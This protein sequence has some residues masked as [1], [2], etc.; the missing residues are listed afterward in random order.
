MEDEEDDVDMFFD[1]Y[2]EVENIP[3]KSQP[4]PPKHDVFHRELKIFEVKLKLV[5]E[6]DFKVSVQE[7]QELEKIFFALN[8]AELNL[9][10]SEDAEETGL[11]EITSLKMRK[12]CFQ[13]WKIN[14]LLNATED[15]SKKLN[16]KLIKVFD[17]RIST[18]EAEIATEE[19]K[20]ST[21][22]AQ[23]NLEAEQ[24]VGKVYSE[25]VDEVSAH[26]MQENVLKKAPKALSVEETEKAVT[27]EPVV[28]LGQ[29]KVPTEEPENEDSPESLKNDV[30]DD[31]K[32]NTNK[33]RESTPDVKE[34]PEDENFFR[35]SSYCR[36]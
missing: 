13:M 28:A 14:N 35:C 3:P 10:A 23:S 4:N 29:E 11:H 25:Q 26:D 7:F 34:E 1:S 31:V 30:G 9:N 12:F 27:E 22:D 24:H 32:N 19:A 5:E 2:I 15:S 8:D 16:R 20:I 6:N 21:T 17:G 33:M 36:S 18:L